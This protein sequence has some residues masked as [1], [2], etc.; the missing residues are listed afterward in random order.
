MLTGWLALTASAL[1]CAV[2]S[3]A[4]RHAIGEIDRLVVAAR[5][6]APYP[7]LAVSV[8]RGG[9]AIYEEVNGYADL[10]QE[11]RAT[12]ETVFHIGSLTKSF[13]AIIIA[14][15]ATEGKIDLD[16]PVGT[17]LPDY[18]GPAKNVAIRHLMNHTAGIVNY[19][20]LPGFPRGD[21]RNT[22]RAEI[23]AYFEKA[24]LMFEPGSAFFYSNSGTYLLGLIIEAVTEKT[25]DIVLKE[26]VLAPLGLER[27]YYGARAPIIKRRA[28]GYARGPEGFSNAPEL[29]PRVSFSAGALLSTVED[30]QRYLEQV[31]R[32]NALGDDM[33]NILYEQDK[34]KSGRTLEYALGG[35]VIREWEGRKKIGHLGD[36]DGFSAYMSFYPQDDA[37]VV[38]MGN[39]RDVT[40][41]V[42]GLEQKIAR[43]V[44]GVPQ[45]TPSGATLRAGEVLALVG[46]YDAGEIRVG[47]PRIG[48]LPTEG[49]LAFRFG[50]SEAGGPSIPLIHIE[51][52]RFMAAHDDEM[53]FMFVPSEGGATDLVIDWL[54]GAIPF[55][56]SGGLPGPAEASGP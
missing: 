49:G 4:D 36:I 12:P 48:V 33:R 52:R 24:D 14:G 32:K 39:T 20:H 38:I 46:D 35:L 53:M 56:R 15:L 17:Y 5:A 13:T 45:P 3:Q 47:V 21:P 6:K 16:A 11:V 19:I 41:S 37:S 43:V 2:P 18:S 50:G 42:V 27:T 7:A 25:Y 10:E 29:D 30:I 31:H 1:F 9:K 44:F 26:R 54:G 23:L 28:R 34:L 40:P 8:H 55:H 22:T 51:G